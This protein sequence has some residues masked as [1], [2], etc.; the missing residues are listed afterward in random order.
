MDGE[1]ERLRETGREEETWGQTSR[2]RETDRQRLERS[3]Q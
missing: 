3:I 1:K 2:Q